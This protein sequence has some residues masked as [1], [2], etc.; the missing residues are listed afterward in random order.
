MYVC[1]AESGIYVYTCERKWLSVCIF[2]RERERKSVNQ[3]LTCIYV[4]NK[5]G[6]RNGS[7]S[8]FVVRAFMRSRVWQIDSS[9]H[10]RSLSRLYQLGNFRPIDWIIIK[11]VKLMKVKN[12]D[13]SFI[14][15]K[16]K[17]RNNSAR[18]FEI[19]IFCAENGVHS[20]K[21]SFSSS[22]AS[23]ALLGRLLSAS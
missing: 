23:K 4:C 20:Y 9:A 5:T 2:E 10:K 7:I 15:K 3:S 21:Y 13:S 1:E 19:R 12:A 18:C 6:E 14:K 11:L 17:K 16:K 22:R 8:L